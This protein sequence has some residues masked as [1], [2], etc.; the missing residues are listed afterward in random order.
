MKGRCPDLAFRGAYEL[1]GIKNHSYT[2][3]L[4]WGSQA[5]ALCAS[6][7]PLPVSYWDERLFLFDP[8]GS[9]EGLKHET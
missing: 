7:A 4:L 6:L 8:D 9:F 1:A 2:A 3:S 5:S